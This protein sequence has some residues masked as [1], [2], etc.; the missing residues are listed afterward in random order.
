MH[1]AVLVS[2]LQYRVAFRLISISMSYQSY[3]W[4][5]M[6]AVSETVEVMHHISFRPSVTALRLIV[7]F[8]PDFAFLHCRSTDSAVV[9]SE[10][11]LSLSCYEVIRPV[12]GLKL[13]L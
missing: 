13:P 5:M 1:G 10:S 8:A 2:A 12:A 6:P 4:R 7:R 3:S 9:H 11:I